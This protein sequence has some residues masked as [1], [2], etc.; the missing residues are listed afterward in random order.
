[1][2]KFRLHAGMD[3]V[4]AITLFILFNQSPFDFQVTGVAKHAS[5]A[6]AE[7]D[8]ERDILE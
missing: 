7:L 5:Q 6:A 3:G 1:M 2:E 4:V 8:R